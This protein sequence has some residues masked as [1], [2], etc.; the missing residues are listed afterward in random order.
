MSKKINYGTNVE[1]LTKALAETNQR[2]KYLELQNKQL[3]ER[4]QKLESSSKRQRQVKKSQQGQLTAAKSKAK[5]IKMTV[6]RMSRKRKKTIKKNKIRV[7][8]A[9]KIKI[10]SAKM[11]KEQVFEM[12]R[13]HNQRRFWERVFLVHP[14]INLERLEEMKAVVRKMSSSLLR[15]MIRTAGLRSTWYD[16]DASWNSAELNG[17]DEENLYALVMSYNIS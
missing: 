3:K 5:A 15:D 9:K 16:S 10:E 1:A 2:I 13:D 11:S 6:S 17:W 12:Y 4:I 7:E 8:K 14:E